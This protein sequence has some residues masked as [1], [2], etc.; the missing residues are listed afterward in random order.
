MI[1]KS[2]TSNR[3]TYIKKYCTRTFHKYD[4]W[5]ALDFEKMI[6][7]INSHDEDSAIKLVKFINGLIDKDELLDNALP[8]I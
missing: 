2:E 8:S 4:I 5:R 7:I 1:D 3:L 6:K